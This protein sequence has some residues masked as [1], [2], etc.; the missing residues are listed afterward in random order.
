MVFSRSICMMECCV[1]IIQIFVNARAHD[2]YVDCNTRQVFTK[3]PRRVFVPWWR[4][5]DAWSYIVYQLGLLWYR[6]NLIS[7]DHILFK[8]VVPYYQYHLQIKEDQLATKSWDNIPAGYSLMVWDRGRV[9]FSSQMHDH[10]LSRVRM[11]SSHNICYWIACVWC[12]LCLPSVMWIW[13]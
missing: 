3:C 1:S 13:V 11:S 6:N 10:T 8:S 2:L 4:Q 5:Y 7:C 12:E 9:F